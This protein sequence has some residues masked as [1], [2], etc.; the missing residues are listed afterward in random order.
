MLVI[1]L[2]GQ[3]AAC[4]VAAAFA[5]LEFDEHLAFYNGLYDQP[6]ARLS[7]YFFGICMGYI[8]HKT[9]EKLDINI[10]IVTCGECVFPAILF[11]SARNIIRAIKHSLE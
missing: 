9:D 2:F 5:S 10:V 1:W 7:P 6:W 4:A 8:L 3:W 11:L